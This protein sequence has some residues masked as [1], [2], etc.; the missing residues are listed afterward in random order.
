MT[1]GHAI[2]AGD[3]I[4]NIFFH[5][6]KG[7]KFRYVFVSNI[8]LDGDGVATAAERDRLINMVRSWGGLVEDSITT[9]PITCHGCSGPLSP[10]PAEKDRYDHLLNAAKRLGIPVL[11]SSHFLPMVNAAARPGATARPA[12][13]SNRRRQPA[14]LAAD[15]RCGGMSRGDLRYGVGSAAWGL[16][17]EWAAGAIYV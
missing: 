14:T 3:F 10:T 13:S 4:S 6:D 15:S 8:D 1:K 9:R 5:D 17:V 12:A 7:R 16:F 2:Q 11:N